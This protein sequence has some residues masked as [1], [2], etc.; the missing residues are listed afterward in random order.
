VSLR[1][2]E[3]F[4][5]AFA[6]IGRALA[7]W[8]WDGQRR[9]IMLTVAGPLGADIADDGPIRAS[10]LDAIAQAGDPYIPVVVRSYG[11]QL[12]RLAADVTV[13]P[14]VL[15]EQVEAA[16]RAGLEARYSFAAR[17]FG[18]PV[19]LS[20]VVGVIQATRGVVGVNVRALYRSFPAGDPPEVHQRLVAALPRQGL[21]ARETVPAELLMLA[22][23]GADLAVSR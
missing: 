15:P 5:Q 9:G 2:Y 4:A 18:Q 17:D 23:G 12:F 21:R 16:I 6:G 11:R 20:E 3:D 8:T 10:L 14:D 22:P 1:D 19:A 13:A 7:T